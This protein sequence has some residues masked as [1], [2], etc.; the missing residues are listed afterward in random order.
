MNLTKNK[1][2]WTF[3]PF[4]SVKL[5]LKTY[6]TAP[7]IRSSSFLRLL[8]LNFRIKSKLYLSI[9]SVA[10]INSITIKCLTSERALRLS[11]NNF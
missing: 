1:I 10:G 5:V 11:R 6:I 4:H 9:H 7:V 8:T 3:D 2:N